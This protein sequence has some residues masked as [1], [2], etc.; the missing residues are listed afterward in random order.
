MSIEIEA[1]MKVEDVSHLEAS[2]LNLGA[3]KGPH[4]H[5]VNT[6]FDT[7]HHSLKSTDQGLRIRIERAREGKDDTIT[8]TH[9]GPRAHSKLKSRFETELRVNDAAA[10]ASLLGA[11]GYH[12]VLSFEKLR[13]KWTLD[14]CNVDID[15]LPHLGHFVEIEG[16]SDNVVLGVR[17]KLHLGGLPIVRASYIAL[18]LTYLSEHHL[19]AEH[20]ALDAATQ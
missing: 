11:L 10:A 14:A 1:K 12:P 4:I 19:T 5:E 18:M 3:V 6:F 8:I 2:L 20:V 13:R 16:P 9:K 7:R 17:E 15:T